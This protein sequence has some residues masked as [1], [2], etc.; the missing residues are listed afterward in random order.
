MTSG[1]PVNH[2][3]RSRAICKFEEYNSKFLPSSKSVV[4]INDVVEHDLGATGSE[5]VASI[6]FRS[7]QEGRQPDKRDSRN[8]SL[9]ILI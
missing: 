1:Y 5:S 7:N 3:E 8:S 6:S 4:G 2:R 9:L